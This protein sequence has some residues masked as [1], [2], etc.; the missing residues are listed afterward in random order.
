MSDI[1]LAYSKLDGG[2]YVGKMKQEG[3][4]LRCTGKRTDVTNDVKKAFIIWMGCPQEDEIKKDT[5]KIGG[6]TY[7]I[8]VKCISQKL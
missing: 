3:N 4:C 8:S 7:E 6:N 5:V 1:R 2:F